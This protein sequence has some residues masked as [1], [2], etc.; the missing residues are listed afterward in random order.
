MFLE[1]VFDDFVVL[2]FIYLEEEDF[3]ELEKMLQLLFVVFKS[4]VNQLVLQ[5]FGRFFLFYVKDEFSGIYFVL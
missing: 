1:L 5:F 3:M 4:D 2:F